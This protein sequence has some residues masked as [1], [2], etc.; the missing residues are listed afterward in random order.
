[1]NFPDLKNP[2]HFLA[3][4]G[5]VGLLPVAPGTFGSLFAALLFVFLAHFINMTLATLFITVL[6]IWICETI[7][8]D[9]QIKDHKA[10]VIDELV[11]M[12]IS[13]LPTLF[14]ASQN[15]RL[16]YTIVAIFVFRFFD[17]TKPRP[18][19]YFDKK[20][21]NGFGIVF[22]DVLAGIFTIFVACFLSLFLFS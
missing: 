21:K 8:K 12:W 20:F 22:D 2:Y 4:L 16:T 9:L 14:L 11:G 1:M 13:L 15:Q 10:I 19:S 5:G 6:A 17:I 7:S 3:T 18:I